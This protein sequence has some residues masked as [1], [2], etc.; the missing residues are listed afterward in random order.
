MTFFLRLLIICFSLFSVFAKAIDTIYLDF[1]F[2]LDDELLTEI[3]EKSNVSKEN[4]R[5]FTQA[6]EYYVDVAPIEC[7]ASLT[8]K[9]QGY[10][11]YHGTVLINAQQLIYQAN[12][13]KKKNIKGKNAA[14]SDHNLNTILCECRIMFLNSKNNKVMFATT[15]FAYDHFVNRFIAVGPECYIKYHSEDWKLCIRTVHKDIPNIKKLKD[16][17][18]KTIYLDFIADSFTALSSQSLE[19]NNM[20]N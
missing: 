20:Y 10:T 11:I 1:D 2:Y 5:F 15:G 18:G 16:L 3:A 4:L 8:I 13:Q 17:I 6:K 9:K 12:T 7:D 19:H 14:N